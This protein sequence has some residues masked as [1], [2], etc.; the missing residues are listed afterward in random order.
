MGALVWLHLV[1]AG[2]WLGGLAT[3]AVVILTALR[4]L[5]RESFRLLVRRVGWTFAAL[6]AV[7]WLLIGASGLALAVRLG[8]PSLVVL[9]TAVGAALLLASGLHVLTGRLTA[10]R[11]A[12]TVSRGLAVLVFAGTLWIFWLGVQ[13]AEAT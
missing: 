6:S 3:L 9:K 4:T 12:V 2:L 13:V 11:P 8:W 1:G 7:S 5:P 10:S